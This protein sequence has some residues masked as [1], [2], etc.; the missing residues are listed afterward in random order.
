MKIKGEF[1]HPALGIPTQIARKRYFARWKSSMCEGI[2]SVFRVGCQCRKKQCHEQIKNAKSKF[3]WGEIFLGAF[4][5]ELC[6]KSSSKVAPLLA[7]VI[8]CGR[9]V[10]RCWAFASNER[11]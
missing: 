11:P 10:L 4:F 7:K 8:T 1:H 3:Q 6:E 2:P 5:S 9:E